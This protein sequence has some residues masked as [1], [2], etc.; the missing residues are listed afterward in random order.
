MPRILSEVAGWKGADI[1]ISAKNT[2]KSNTCESERR[3]PC[4]S[5]DLRRH[6]M[7]SQC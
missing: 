6:A 2:E 1:T 3:M 4:E 5:C 7:V